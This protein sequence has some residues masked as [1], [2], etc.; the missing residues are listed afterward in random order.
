MNMYKPEGMLIHTQRN[1]EYI[2]SRDG[3]RRALEGNIILEAPCIMSDNNLNLYVSLGTD[4]R[5]II[6][7]D[8]VVL[9]MG[10]E[11]KDIAI[12]TRVGRTVCFVVSGFS[13][14]EEGKTVCYLS[15]RRAQELCK[16]YY[17][18]SLLPGDIIDGKVTHLEGFGAFVDIGCGVISLLPIDQISISR[19]SHPRERVCAGDYI[20]AVV[21]ARDHAERIFLSTKELLGTWEENA[22]MFSEGETVRGTVRGIMPYGI[23]IELTPNLAGLAEFRDGVFENQGATVYIK[24]ILPDRMKIKLILI[25]T[26]DNEDVRGHQKLFFDTL[27]TS[28]IDRFIYSPPSCKRRIE[29]VF[30]EDI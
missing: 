9:P 17:L 3:L 6:P 13:R 21:R 14:D 10:E 27:K 23:F 16:L 28:H 30:G 25:D 24:S 8:E 4:I 22:S 29:T 2:S 12:L 1:H 19:I 20:K 15:R 26:Y 11:V 5:G 7:R 18:D